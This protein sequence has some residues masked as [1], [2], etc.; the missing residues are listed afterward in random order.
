MIVDVNA[1][2]VKSM[3]SI[4]TLSVETWKHCYNIKLNYHYTTVCM[5]VCVYLE[6]VSVHYDPVFCFSTL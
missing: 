3:L 4:L 5:R 6:T 2:K 1:E